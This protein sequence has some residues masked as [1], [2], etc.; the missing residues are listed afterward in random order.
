MTLTNC[1]KIEELIIKRNIEELSDSEVDTLEDHLSTCNSCR[2]FETSLQRINQ[3]M[4]VEENETLTPSPAIREKILPQMRVREKSKEN[5]FDTFFKSIQNLLQYRVPVYQAGVALILAFILVGIG[6]NVPFSSVSSSDSMDSFVQGEI[7]TLDS[8]Y[9]INNYPSL[10]S[11]N[12][13]INVKEDTMLTRFI[14]NS[15]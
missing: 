3:E 10:D 2:S 14:F 13:G 4:Q 8:N 15:M 12:V 1:S 11:Q 5:V 9:L 6:V 7:Q